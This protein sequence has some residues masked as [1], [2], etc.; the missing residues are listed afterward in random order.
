MTDIA[1]RLLSYAHPNSFVGDALRRE[2]QTAAY[3]IK[4]LRSTLEDS[5]K[6]IQALE[7]QTAEN[8]RL[9]AEIGRLKTAFRVNMLLFGAS[10]TDIDKVLTRTAGQAVTLTR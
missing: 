4:R 9:R 2:L 5:S 6:Y 3:E 1:E 8:E 10:D 7:D